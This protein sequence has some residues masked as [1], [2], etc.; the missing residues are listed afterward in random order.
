MIGLTIAQCPSVSHLHALIDTLPEAAIPVVRGMLERLQTWPPSEP[1]EARAIKKAG[2]ER[3]RQTARPG[4]RG[5]G[6]GYNIGP[7]GKS[8]MAVT[9]IVFGRQ[10]HSLLI[11]TYSTRVT[12]S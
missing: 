12:S 8:N 1:P 7:A 4:G 5:S 10:T 9:A 2:V 6:G 11:G 3:L